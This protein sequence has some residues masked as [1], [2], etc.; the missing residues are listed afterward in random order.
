MKTILMLVLL[1]LTS[2]KTSTAGN[3]SSQLANSKPIRVERI[4]PFMGEFEFT[5]P[6]SAISSSQPLPPDVKPTAIVTL[7]EKNRIV[8]SVNFLRLLLDGGIAPPGKVIV[9]D[10]NGQQ[11]TRSLA[12]TREPNTEGEVVRVYRFV[13]TND[14][15]SVDDA[16]GPAKMIV[17]RYEEYK[18]SVATGYFS[19]TP[20]TS[21]ERRETFL[22]WSTKD[23]MTFESVVETTQGKQRQILN[24]KRK[25]PS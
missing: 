23:V 1:V 3:Q 11:N 14:L 21:Y 20:W 25:T 13:E 9:Y 22:K 19:R 7:D 16:M 17:G 2:C 24:F 15:A 5:G 18:R 12:T 4:A 8:L 6:E 10:Y